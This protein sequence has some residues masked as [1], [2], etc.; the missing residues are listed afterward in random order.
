MRIGSAVDFFLVLEIKQK[1]HF[2]SALI[3]KL[4]S[5]SPKNQFKVSNGKRSFRVRLVIALVS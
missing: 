4:F 3:I 2:I 5:L 1:A